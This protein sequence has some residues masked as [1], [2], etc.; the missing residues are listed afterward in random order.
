MTLLMEKSVR[1]LLTAF[2][3][4]DPT[5]G[6]GSASALASA[7][8]A[9]LL[10]MVAGL[11][12]TRSNT[13]EDRAALDQALAAL[14]QLRDQL[15]S[16]VDADT[17]AYDQVV[18]AYRLPKASPADQQARKEAIQRALRSAID[19]PVG[20]MKMSA[21]AIRRGAVVAAHGNR[22]AASDIG[23]AAALLQAGATGARL[24]VDINL[25]SVSDSTYLEALR[26]E[27]NLIATELSSAEQALKQQLES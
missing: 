27:L 25:Q 19:V 10:M 20:V 16:A 21:Q 11:P 13:P 23:V 18:A 5:P 14:S 2:S 6:G 17:A 1:D 3:S 12:K 15:A 22:A 24:N 8:G 7:V 4:S 26:G 9:S